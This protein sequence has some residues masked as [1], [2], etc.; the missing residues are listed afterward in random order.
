MKIKQLVILA[1]VAACLAGC[2]LANIFTKTELAKPELSVPDNWPVGLEAS[3]STQQAIPASRLSWQEFFENPELRRLIEQALEH[4]C[5]LKLA[6]LNVERARAMYGIKKAALYPTLDLNLEASRARIPADISYSNKAMTTEQYE[7]GVG[8]PSWEIDFWGRMESL[9]NEAFE[10]FLATEQARRSVQIVLISEI[11]RTYLGMASDMDQLRLATSLLDIQNQIYDLVRL[12]FEAGIA[13]ELAVKQAQ[14]Q[15]DNA[16]K[17]VSASKQAIEQGKNA[18]QLLVGTTI[19]DEL[20]PSSLSS[21][22]MASQVLVEL[23]SE[24]L[25]KRPDIMAS[26]HRL[27]ASNANIEAARTALFP[28]ISLTTAFGTSSNE[29]TGL[30]SKGS[31][32]WQFAPGVSI[33]IFDARLWSAYDAAKVEGDIALNEYDKAIQKA[34]KETAD[35]LVSR[36]RL[37]EQ[38]GFQQAIVSAASDA[39]AL[40]YVR[41][42]QGIDSYLSVCDAQKNLYLTQQGLVALNFATL[43]SKV[44]LYA[45]LGGGSFS[46]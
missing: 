10:S 23:P 39:Y 1:G 8:V 27:R 7:V 30:F 16:Q 18:L 26:E 21:L 2:N 24:A 44:Q 46:R 9:K 32:A 45:V 33:P 35:A 19:S 28:R 43:L 6:A 15:V 5:D 42:E 36:Q 12:R 38:S 40:S 34:F 22:N 25:L 20:M 37:E 4:N 13:S 31:E 41:F 3:V 17:A 29:L 11:A 14:A